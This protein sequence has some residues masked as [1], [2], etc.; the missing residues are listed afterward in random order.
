MA[1]GGACEMDGEVIE[2]I[3]RIFTQHRVN[4]AIMNSNMCLSLIIY[5]RD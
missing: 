3:G 1:V 4:K 5:D 2:S